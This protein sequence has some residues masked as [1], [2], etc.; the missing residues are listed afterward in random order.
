[1]TLLYKGSPD[2]SKD[3]NRW[4][5]CPLCGKYLINYSKNIDAHRCMIK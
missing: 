2:L 4:I 5:K 1:M 3:G